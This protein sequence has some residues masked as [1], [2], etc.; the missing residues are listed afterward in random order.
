MA[1]VEQHW[2]R[3]SLGSVDA[4]LEAPRWDVRDGGERENRCKGNSHVF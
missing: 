3:E 4:C 1:V 2:G